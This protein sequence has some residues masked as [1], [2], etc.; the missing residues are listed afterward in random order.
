MTQPSISPSLT[1]EQVRGARALLGLGEEKFADLLHITREALIE[2]ERSHGPLHL[3]TEMATALSGAIINAGV[4]L[5]DSGSYVGIG[6]PGV[7]LIGEPVATAEVID[8]EAAQ[9]AR[10]TEAKAVSA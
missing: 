3:S 8:L 7:R 9:T 1:A 5:I 4:H 6:G 2:M 10:P